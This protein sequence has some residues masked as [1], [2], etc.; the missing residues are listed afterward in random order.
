MEC[1]GTYFLVIYIPQ[2]V[3]CTIGK[4][5]SW[6]FEAGYYIYVGSAMEPAKSLSSAPF[7]SPANYHP[8]A[9]LRRVIRHCRPP[10]QKKLHWHID[11]LLQDP[12]IQIQRIGLLPSDRKIECECAELI[13]SIADSSVLGFGCSDCHCQSHLFYF[14]QSPPF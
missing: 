1:S 8:G 5:S 12:R 4:L 11:Y 14:S 2:L 9:L 13:S 10:S 7:P 6:H 3:D